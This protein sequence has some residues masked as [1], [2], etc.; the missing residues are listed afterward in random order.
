MD[1]EMKINA[2][3]L[4]MEAIDTKGRT[5]M[6]AQ[7]FQAE[8]LRLEKLMYHVSW[9]MLRSDA[10]CADA[11]QEAILKAWQK[12]G[13]L[14]DT[15]SFKPWVMRILVNECN[16]ILRRKWRS[17]APLQ[18]DTAVA[19]PP[20]PPTPLSEAIAALKPEHRLAVTLHYGENMSV[21]EIA[22]LLG[23]P[24]GTVKTRLMTARNRLRDMLQ[25]DW[26]EGLL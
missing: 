20:A 1:V 3:A 14:R 22:G 17:F 5:R 26:K 18:E 19:L 15:D 10:D 16:T 12:I 6:D 13:G 9:A 21:A 8:V 11:V 2:R 24:E 25:E 7:T 4:P 23:I